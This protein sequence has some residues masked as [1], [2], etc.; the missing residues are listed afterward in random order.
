MIRIVRPPQPP[1]ELEDAAGETAA[2]VSEF[3]SGNEIRIKPH[4]YSNDG[5]RFALSSAQF[6]KCAFCE[7]IVNMDGHVE[8][9]RPKAAVRDG[10]GQPLSRP[11]YVWLAY[12][13]TNLLLAC[14]DCNSRHK[15]NLFPPENPAERVRDP[16]G[17]CAA[18]RPL[19][20]NPAEEDPEELIEWDEYIPKA[21]GGNARAAATIGELRLNDPVDRG[22]VES[23]RQK[24][25]DIQSLIDCCSIAAELMERG[26]ALLRERASASSEYAAMVRAFLRLRLP[27]LDWHSTD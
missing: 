2:L 6:G 4:V 16:E 20:I 7:R 1:G 13:W 12:S 25:R 11:G 26:H 23:R 24:F 5:V 14:G 15:E 27:D 21:R 8:H 19:F 18:E 3:R 10:R 9:F 22:V 17:D